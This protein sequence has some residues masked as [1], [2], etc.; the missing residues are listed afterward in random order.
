MKRK[1]TPSSAASRRPVSSEAPRRSLPW[2]GILLVVGGLIFLLQSFGVFSWWD[3]WDIVSGGWSIW[4]VLW[5]F[6]PVLLVILG[7]YVIWGRRNRW[8]TAGLIVLVV[9]LV[10]GFSFY[11]GRSYYFVQTT[12]DT[13]SQAREDLTS[14]QLDIESGAAVLVVDSLSAD[15]GDLVQSTFERM[16]SGSGLSQN[17][18]KEEGVGKVRLATPR[19]S[20]KTWGMTQQKWRMFL[21]P[22]IPLELNLKAGAGETRLVLTDL[23]ISR[24]LLEIGASRVTVNLPATGR[25]EAVIHAG[26][27]DLLVTVPEGVAVRVHMSSAIA[28]VDIDEIRFPKSGD[29]YLS[30]DF[31]NSPNRVD[32]EIDAGVAKVKVQ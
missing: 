18:Q 25:T 14:A 28:S 13:F 5:R 9:L 17:F 24:L 19:Q 21:S 31:A 1:K 20:W 16:S 23:Q 22:L 32:L 4:V 6:W 29:Y 11:S 7:I 2:A 27:A 12:V 30:A 26:V 10:A 8:L 3:F 15:S